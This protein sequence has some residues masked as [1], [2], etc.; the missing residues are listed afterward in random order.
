[1]EDVHV[2]IIGAGFGGLGAAIRLREEGFDDLVVLEREQRLG[3][4]W[5]QNTYPGCACDVPAHLYSFSFALNPQWSRMFAPQEE[6]LAYLER[7]AAERGVLPRI[8]FGADVEEARWDDAEQRWLIRTSRG[9]LRARV[10][11]QA[12]GPLSEPCRPDIPGLDTFAGTMFHSARWDHDH[13]L[14]G[15]RV[16][17]IGTGASSAQFIPHVQPLAQRLT[18][19][20]R[21]PG[22]VM[23]RI[24][25]PHPDGLGRLMRRVPLIQRAWRKIVYYLAE[26]LVYGLVKDQRA[27]AP[28]EAVARWHLRRTISDPALRTRLEPDYRIGCKRIIF[29]NDYLPALAQ[30]NVDLVTERITEVVPQGVRTADGVLHEADTIIL[31]TGFKPFRSSTYARI[32]GADGRTLADRWSDERGGPQAYRGTAVAGFPNHFMLIGPNTGLGNNSMIN[33]IEGQ[34]ALVVDA[35]HAM[36]RERLEA[37]DVRPEAQEAHNVAIQ[38]R[39]RG[40]VWTDGGCRSWY[41]TPE[42]INRTLYPG[43]SDQFRRSVARFPAEDFVVSG[44]DRSRPP[45]PQAA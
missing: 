20:Q 10:L 11:I 13:D 41:L 8:R 4:T 17:V 42:G 12:T 28:T 35:L 32:R 3:G 29:A 15:E 33:I 21:T 16:A 9:D 24:D 37:V 34:L 18:V 25:F 27:L 43:Y 2:A 38:E 39:M 14:R 44:P 45:Q 1:M 19:F 31:G 7:T 23:P 22:W 36:R 30:P 26:T 6:I 40:T 5:W